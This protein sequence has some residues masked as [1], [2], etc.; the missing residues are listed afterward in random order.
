MYVCMKNNNN[1][2]NNIVYKFIY[3]YINIITSRPCFY[4]MKNIY[5]L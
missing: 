2:N 3:I 1:N 5:I 4:T